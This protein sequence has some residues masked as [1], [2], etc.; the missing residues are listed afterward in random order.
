M[1][2]SLTPYYLILA[3]SAFAIFYYIKRS[4]S[5]DRFWESIAVVT[6]PIWIG[7]PSCGVVTVLDQ[8]F[9]DEQATA[10][11][12]FLLFGAWLVCWQYGDEQ[13]RHKSKK[14]LSN[15]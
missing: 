1:D 7:L 2:W 6:T 10:I 8:T 11:L 12:G 4:Y 3:C 15:E 13:K 9:G 5:Q 14:G